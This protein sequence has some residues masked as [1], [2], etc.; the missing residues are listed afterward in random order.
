MSFAWAN[1]A[2]EVAAGAKLI[3]FD[4]ELRAKAWAMHATMPAS[5]RAQFP[6]PEELYSFFFAADALVAPPPGA[7]VLER[8]VTVELRPGRVAVRPPG[9]DR[10]FT[11]YQQTAD[12]WKWVVPLGAVE[13]A[14]KILHNET[15][16]KLAPAAQP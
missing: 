3:W 1:D 4:D 8:F 2:G 5:L 14:P 9:S 12:G 10:N 6:T 7:D 15:L 13:N 11:E 16:L